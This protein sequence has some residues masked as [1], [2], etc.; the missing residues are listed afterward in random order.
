MNT[1]AIILYRNNMLKKLHLILL[2]SCLASWNFAQVH[3]YYSSIDFSLP[4]AQVETSL[5]NLISST[6]DPLTYSETYTWLKFTDQD[7]ANTNNVVLMYN[8]QSV[9]KNYTVGGGNTSNPEIWNREHV[10]PQS[11]I[12]APADADLHHLRACDADINNTRGNSPFVSGN[13]SYSG[14]S[15][16]W[17]PGDDWR[18]DVARML[19]YMNLRYNEPFSEIGN[20]TLFLQWNVQDP[21]SDFERQRNNT[22]YNAQGNRNPFIDQPYIA[23][24]LWGGDAAED[25][26]GWPNTVL[27]NALDQMQVYPNPAES[28]TLVTISCDEALFGLIQFIELH[29]FDGK[30]I[31]RFEKTNLL[32]L[33]CIPTGIYFLSI[34]LTGKKRH[35][36]IQID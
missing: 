14:T 12:N 35:F 9:N 20:L 5:K 27:E 18:G 23:T 25:L 3:P 36:K 28:N 24:Y 11:M 13:G 32:Q 7:L 1:R 30:L 22:I 33:P 17:Y 16:T 31:S 34:E 10:Y 2:V 4:A 6:H 19:M 15:S 21:V 26:W 8:G 29:S